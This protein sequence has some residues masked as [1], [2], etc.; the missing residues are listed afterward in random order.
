MALGHPRPTN[1]EGRVRRILRQ[2]GRSALLVLAAILLI[3]I[4][5]SNLPALGGRHLPGDLEE[6]LI[7]R[8]TTCVTDT[9]IWPGEPRQPECGQVLID[10]LGEGAVPPQAQ[11]R[12]IQRAV[13][14]QISITTPNWTTQGT[15][16]HEI[17][18]HGRTVSKVAVEQNGD[19]SAYPDEDQADEARWT[20]YQCPGDF[21]SASYNP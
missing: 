12:G 18:V 19:W 8:Y 16:R 4:V 10:V 3:W 2:P 13:C 7:Q 6:S 21:Q 17:V 5:V 1:V 15:T 9:A 14:Y 11:A 20:L